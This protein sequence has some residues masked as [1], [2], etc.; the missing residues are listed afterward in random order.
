MLAG[1]LIATS[2]SLIWSCVNVLHTL[3]QIDE[4]NK[5]TVLVAF[6]GKAKPNFRW[7]VFI[8]KTATFAIVGTTI[9]YFFS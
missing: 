9:G 6:Q 5:D 8:L 2:I 3:H 7:H 4:H 1:F